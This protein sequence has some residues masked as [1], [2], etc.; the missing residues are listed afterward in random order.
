VE[1]GDATS[2]GG[3]VGLVKVRNVGRVQ[4][5]KVKFFKSLRGHGARV[6]GA[7]RR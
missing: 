7:R 5:P 4:L 3:R 6:G 1:E 2:S